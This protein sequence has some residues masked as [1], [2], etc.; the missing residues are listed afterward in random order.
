MNL[1]YAGEV[2]SEV[3]ERFVEH[4]MDKGNRVAAINSRIHRIR[5]LRRRFV[6]FHAQYQDKERK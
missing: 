6:V 5:V 3:V 2:D 4:E 1:T